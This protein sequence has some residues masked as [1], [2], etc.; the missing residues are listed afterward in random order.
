M[1]EFGEID[2]PV[3]A[4]FEAWPD[5]P[6]DVGEKA[7]E[8]ALAVGGIVFPPLEVFRILKEQFSN[9]ERFAR[10][11]YLFGA[12]RAQLR[13]IESASEKDRERLRAVQEAIAGASFHEAV[14]VACEESVRA[15]KLCKID[16]F[17]L[18]LTGS[19]TPNQWADPS[20]DIGVMIRDIAQLGEKDLEVLRILASVHASAISHA[21]NLN[22]PDSF[23]RE[24][25]TLKR[26]VAESRIHPDDFLAICE[27]VR[28]F[29]LAAEVLRNTS[30]IGA[31]RLLLPS[32]AA[33][34][35]RP[36]ISRRNGQRGRSCERGAEVKGFWK[37]KKPR[38]QP[39]RG[40]S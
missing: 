32:H 28:G 29:G 2:N 19:L 4:A 31:S 18:I 6:G 13:I 35:C 22:D 27:R 20:E 21:P 10:V 38:L 34:S 11:E 36:G 37:K 23:S 1:T 39:G 3:D 25:P 16:Q 14:A 5:K 15:I 40:I 9:E 8:V 12:I 26:R 24:T 30:H 33:W 7:K 17:A